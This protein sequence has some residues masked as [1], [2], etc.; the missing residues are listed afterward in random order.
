MLD[1][2]SKNTRAVQ[3]IQGFTDI[4]RQSIGRE[5]LSYPRCSAAVCP[6]DK[7]WSK[8]THI[9]YPASAR[10]RSSS[11]HK[12]PPRNDLIESLC[13]RLSPA[14]VPLIRIVLPNQF[15]PAL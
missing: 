6:C 9:I 7:D 13:D 10:R 3:H 1:L 15:R 12:A 5:H 14:C 11:H 8:F 2:H 4:G